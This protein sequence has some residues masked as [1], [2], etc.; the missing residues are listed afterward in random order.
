MRF[1][2]AVHPAAIFGAAIEHAVRGAGYARD[3]IGTIRAS[4]ETRDHSVWPLAAAVLRPSEL[5]DSAATGELRCRTDEA[6]SPSRAI[7][8]TVLIHRQL[9]ARPIT[10][11]ASTRKA[12]DDLELRRVSRRWN[13][14]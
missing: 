3:R 8:C 5:I 14:K 11:G 7:D 2:R 4:F 9:T 1:V 10:A 13:E 6:S 12:M